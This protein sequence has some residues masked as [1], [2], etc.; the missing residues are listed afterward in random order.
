MESITYVG[1]D[2]HKATISVAIA[3][4]GRGGEVRYWGKIRNEPAAVGR[5]ARK[6]GKQHERLRFS[7]EAG[8]CGYGLQ[9][10]LTA[11]GHE[12]IVAA[13]SLI[14]RA[15][16]EQVQ[17]DRLDALTLARVDRAGE[18]EAIWVPDPAHEAIRDLV[19]GREA[20]MRS[21]NR[22]RQQLLGFLLRQGRVYPGKTHWTKAHQH[23]LD[24]QSFEH[25]AH[26]ILFHEMR[27]AIREAKARLDRLGEQIAGLM[28][29]WDRAPVATAL[30]AMRGIAQL[31]GATLVAEI[32]CFSRFANPRQLMNYVGLVA[33]EASSGKRVR[34]GPITGAGNSRVRRLLVEAAW[35]YL[36]KPRIG[37]SLSQRQ[38]ELPKEV[39][40]IAWKAQ[41]RLCK[42]FRHLLSRGKPRPLAVTAVAR[43]MLGFI[44]AIACHVEQQ[45]P[46]P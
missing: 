17:T 39:R 8:P 6:L 42:R 41:L 20:A 7:Y 46:A 11:L 2:T 21:H 40:D 14:P 22:V 45:A 43:E 38:E 23:W 15:P 9:R 1:M 26:Q 4:G 44:W 30:T 13:P 18:L 34:R 19:R 33:S 32:G 31:G 29:Q 12:C 3:Q 36:D 37:V 10:Q 5:L 25:A 24:G 35:C 27:E 16:G 28:G